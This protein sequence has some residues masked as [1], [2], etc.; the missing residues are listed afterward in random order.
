MRIGVFVLGVA[1]LL[2]GGCKI[3]TDPLQTLTASGTVT[4]AGEPAPARI[5]LAA[6]NF[7]TTRDYPDGTF[8][9]T[10]G[11]GTLPSSNCPSAEITA[12][13]LASDGQTLLDSET[14]VLG[15][16][17]EHVVDFVFP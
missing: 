7:S 3:T 11:T 4:Q 8:Q 16:C 12:W 1:A 9:I 6:G 2:L 10:A 5:R 13:L 14:R 17:G 15:A